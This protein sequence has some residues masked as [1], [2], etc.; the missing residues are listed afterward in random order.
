MELRAGRTVPTMTTLSHQPFR[1]IR[2]LLSVAGVLCGLAATSSLAQPPRLQLL[3]K[4]QP[5]MWEMRA[6][7]GSAARRMCIASGRQFIQ[8]R[9]AGASCHTQ[10]VEGA[11]DSV[12]VTYT[13]PGAGYGRT[14]IRLETSALAQLESQGIASGL[15]FD[16][17]AEV[18]RVG[19]CTG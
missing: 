2:P 8:I 12:T 17:T 15:P 6:R 18:R 5:G 10:L 9:H 1:M 7:D 3:D 16:F 14:T 19:P 13:C 11:A 4:L